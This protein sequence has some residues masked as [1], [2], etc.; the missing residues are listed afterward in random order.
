MGRFFLF[1][2]VILLVSAGAVLAAL[3][4][5]LPGEVTFPVGNE[6]VAVHSGAAAIGIVVLGGVLALA[7][8]LATALLVL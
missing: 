5:S 8:W 6:I 1:I 3:A 4:F 2:A 7:W